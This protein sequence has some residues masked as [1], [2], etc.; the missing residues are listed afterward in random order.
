MSTAK[1]REARTK[2]RLVTARLFTLRL[3]D[4]N[5]RTDF[6]AKSGWSPTSPTVPCEHDT[7]FSDIYARALPALKACETSDVVAI[8][9]LF[10]GATREDMKL[11]ILTMGAASRSHDAFTSIG[12]DSINHAVT[13]GQVCETLSPNKKWDVG[14][15]DTKVSESLVG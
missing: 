1:D 8:P 6:A 15:L 11:V 9:V 2:M 12:I 3:R 13:M 4:E 5:F 14:A 10:V 7:L